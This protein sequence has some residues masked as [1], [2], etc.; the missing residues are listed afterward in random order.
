MGLNK[1]E[2]G[3]VLHTLRELGISFQYVGPHQT[4]VKVCS[5]LHKEPSGL[6]YYNG[7]D[8]GIFHDLL[9]SVVICRDVNVQDLG[10]NAALL[11]EMDPQEAFY[12]LCTSL[13]HTTPR[14]GIHPTAIIGPEAVIGTDVH[15]GP[16]AVIGR[17]TIGAGS[18]IH[19]HV[20]IMDGCRI[21]ERVTI[22]PHC[23]IGA[24]GAVWMWSEQ[25]ER[26]I[27]PQLGGVDIGN[28]V[29]LSTDVAIVRGLLNEDTRIG[30]RTMIAPGSKI[31]HS[32]TI[33]PDCHLANNVSL[34]GSAYIG[35]GSF[36]GSGS[37][38]R[39]HARLAPDTVV[40]SGAAV[41]KNVEQPGTTIAGVP[42]QELQV[43][44]AQRK[45]VPRGL[46]RQN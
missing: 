40:G 12:R 41:V 43:S 7:T 6:Y 8:P 15:I 2:L 16:Y 36:L 9:R 35:A 45:G 30:A 38:V 4:I 33:E 13:F 42:A 5:L 31:G 21:G 18:I 10:T 17:C 29:F 46:R 20:V 22:E 14:P 26:L 25:G 39:S 44:K 3:Q 24:T 27:L 23:C 19:G 28:D 37:S 34:A 32:V 11:V 1:V